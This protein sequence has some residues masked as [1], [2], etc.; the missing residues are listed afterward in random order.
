MTQ[1][2]MSFVPLAV[3]LKRKGTIHQRSL[4]VNMHTHNNGHLNRVRYL[5]LGIQET[6]LHFTFPVTRTD[7]WGH[8]LTTVATSSFPLFMFSTGL[9]E[10][11]NS[12]PVHDSLM[13]SFRVD[14]IHKRSH[15][16]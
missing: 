13:L 15:L 6:L 9:W 1:A 16:W 8:P 11:A 5:S 4:A 10:L 3:S 7:R 12:F 2:E 14:T